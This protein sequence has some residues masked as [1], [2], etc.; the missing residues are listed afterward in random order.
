MGAGRRC[1]Y[2]C[3][4]VD[5]VAELTDCTSA[6]L[7]ELRQKRITLK[8]EKGERAGKRRVAVVV[9]RRSCQPWLSAK[10]DP[11]WREPFTTQGAAVPRGKISTTYQR[12]TTRFAA[13]RCSVALLYLQ[14]KGFP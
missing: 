6:V 12:D 3:T 4:K 11:P 5:A 9:F 10:T 1:K 7:A 2:T 14:A 13:A 8:D